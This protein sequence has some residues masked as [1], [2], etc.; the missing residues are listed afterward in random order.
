MPH[1]ADDLS[2]MAKHRVAAAHCD[3]RAD[4]DRHQTRL[5]A[6]ACACT[7]CAAPADPPGC[8]ASR[9]AG[10]LMRAA[11]RRRCSATFGSGRRRTAR[12]APAFAPAPSANTTAS[13]WA[14]SSCRVAAP[15]PRR[16]VGTVRAPATSSR[17]ERSRSS[18]FCG[19]RTRP[20]SL[21]GLGSGPDPTPHRLLNPAR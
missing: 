4:P 11:R 21:W 6:E 20:A 7:V 3:S 5:V 15:A 10:S 16:R 8:G 19:W 13:S 9:C 12:P 14:T 2:S 1:S 18:A 17:P